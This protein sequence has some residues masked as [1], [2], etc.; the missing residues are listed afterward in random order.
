MPHWAAL[1]EK[2]PRVTRVDISLRTSQR[3]E[4]ATNPHGYLTENQSVRGIGD[5]VAQIPHWAALSEK[6]QRVTCVDISL[7]TGRRE[8][9]A[10]N[11]HDRLAENQSV[12]GIGDQ[13]ARIPHWAATSEKNPRPTR[14]DT[15]LGSRQREEPAT[16]SRDCLTENRTARGI[17]GQV[18]R[19]PRRR[20]RIR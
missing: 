4:P 6:N 3:E 15:S 17:G 9:S 1:S 11:P 5:Q 8:E 10:T 13:V 16:R 14:T 19:L 20:E 18:A 2:N 12:R 7:R